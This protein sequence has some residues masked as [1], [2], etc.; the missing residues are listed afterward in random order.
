M[1]AGTCSWAQNTLSVADSIPDPPYYESIGFQVASSA[2]TVYPGTST[3]SFNAGSYQS[4]DAAIAD[5]G[6]NPVDRAGTLAGHVI[7]GVPALLGTLTTPTGLYDPE[8][9]HFS[10]F[11]AGLLN[12]AGDG[13]L[14]EVTVTYEVVPEP[15]TIGVLLAGLG[16]V[17]VSR[18]RR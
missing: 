18:W 6:L 12:L 15:T 13:Y 14:A 3:P 11:S 17:L 2:D 16:L 1:A 4:Y 9:T 8:G 7:L 5:I 10:S